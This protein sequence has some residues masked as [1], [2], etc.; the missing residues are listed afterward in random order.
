VPYEFKDAAQITTVE[1]RGQGTR[2]QPAG[3]WSDDG[4]LMLALLDS[5]LRTRATGEAAFDTTDQAK[6]FLAWRD[7]RDYTPD[8]DGSFDIGNATGAAISRFRNG[9]PAE[10]AGGTNEG[11]QGN[12]SLMRI[13]PIALVERDLPD[14]ELVTHA[15]RSSRVTHGHPVPQAACAL[16]V[17]IA[18]NLLHGQARNEAMDNARTALRHVYEQHAKAA[19]WL[20]ALETIEGWSD[21][22]GRGNVV[23]SFWSAWDAVAGA[24]SYRDAVERAVKYGHDTDT[25]ACIAGGLA[26][27]RWGVEGIPVEWKAGLRGQDIV[28]PLVAALVGDPRA[29]AASGAPVA[30]LP[31]D[32]PAGRRTSATHPIRVDW[33][34][35]A[36]VPTAAGWT[37]E[38]GMTFLPGKKDRGVKGDHWRDLESDVA[39]LASEW[40]VDTFVLLVEDKDLEATKVSRSGIVDS[41]AAHGIDLIRYPIAEAGVPSDKASFADHLASI[42]ERLRSGQR[43]VVACRGGLGRTGTMVGCL[44]RDAGLAGPAAVALT[45]KSRDNTI[46]N[47]DQERFVLTFN[48]KRKGHPV[49]RQS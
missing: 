8:H 14:Q 31:S 49:G 3:T 4:A 21:R 17:L 44:L 41:M 19:M 10:R 2:N 9:T 32:A 15:H 30:P 6:R 46:E 27:I 47:D 48:R 25:T 40:K 12:G 13:L 28:E 7:D 24:T 35:P 34:D 43:V 1:W 18:R 5:L 11:S 16:Y 23:D 29:P 45:R 33:V 39:R 37:G 22:S 36:S 42:E 26:G 38:L 20:G